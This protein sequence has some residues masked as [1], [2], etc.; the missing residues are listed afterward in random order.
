MRLARRLFRDLRTEGSGPGRE[1][2]ALG[3]GAF[4]GCLPFYGFH[5]LLV[6]A[7]G[8]IA[9]LN[10]LKMYAAANISNPFFAPALIF[11]EV[12]FGAWL[13]RQ[14]FHDLTV[15]AIRGT[16]PWVFGGDLL[17]GSLVL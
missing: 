10:R 15:D 9:R 12:Q 1:A 4:I 16:D 6:A 3:V 13:R 17:L 2:A 11:I 14:D 7:V 8:H 5:L